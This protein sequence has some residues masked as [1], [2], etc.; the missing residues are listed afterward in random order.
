MF[1]NLNAEQARYGESN[2]FVAEILGI[3]RASYESKKRNGRF[4]VTDANK[5][6]DHY[7]CDYAYLFATNPIP[8]HVTWRDN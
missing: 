4:S 5:L 7:N 8:P 6:C 3:T 2:T 1:P